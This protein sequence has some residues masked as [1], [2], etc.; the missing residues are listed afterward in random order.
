[1]AQSS[2][3][4]LTTGSLSTAMNQ[5]DDEQRKAIYKEYTNLLS[6]HS[7]KNKILKKHLQKA[8][9]PA[10]AIY[11]VLPQNGVAQAEAKR[12][13]R[14]SVLETAKPMRNAFQKMGKLPFFYA[15]FRC[16]CKASM[17]SA[18]GDSGWDMRWKAND[19]KEIRWD[20]HSCFYHNVLSSYGMP[21]LT[22][23]F[24]ESDDVMYGKIPGMKW[25]RTK[26]I[27]RGAN[28][29]DFYFSRE[30]SK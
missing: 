12:I 3:K 30:D 24:C 9:L 10:V 2:E 27:G 23:I 21:E 8:I 11:R 20:C 17:G 19:K 28:I 25:G 14:Q 7:D 6:E 18:F 4:L 1:M 22:P 26:T 5:I 16:M 13:I 29:C 15:L